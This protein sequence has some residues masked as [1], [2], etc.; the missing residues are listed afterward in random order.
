MSFAG[1]NAGGTNGS[2]AIGATAAKSAGSGAP[3]ASM[4][5]TKNN[6]LVVGVGNDWDHATKH[7]VGAG[8]IMVHQYL[9]PVGDTYWVQR[10]GSTT[11]LSGTTVTINDTAPTTDRYNLSVCEILSAL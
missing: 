10:Q 5:T 8:Q 3:S 7:T 2:G 6:S 1:V 9:A 11:P 4:I